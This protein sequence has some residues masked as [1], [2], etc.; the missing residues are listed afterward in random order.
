MTDI[1]PGPRCRKPSSALTPR[2]A[3]RAT[4]VVRFNCSSVGEQ[5]LH[6]IAGAP[7]ACIGLHRPERVSRVSTWTLFLSIL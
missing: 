3:L 2:A 7:M 4:T 5:Q 1:A 6:T